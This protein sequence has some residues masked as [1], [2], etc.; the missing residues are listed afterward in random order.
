MKTMTATTGIALTLI[1]AAPAFAV[2]GS[3]HCDR[4]P[5][6]EVMEQ[7]DG[8]SALQSIVNQYLVRWEARNATEQCQAYADG[9]PYDIGC[10]NGRRDWPAILASVPEDYFG[11]SNESLAAT[12]REE[13]RKGNG[14]REALA[15][16]RSVGAI[17]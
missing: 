13:K 17:K 14:L 3:F 10:M 5:M 16:C 15:Y 1:G 4:P 8:S 12:V 9:R 7:V 11:R 6:M 2:G